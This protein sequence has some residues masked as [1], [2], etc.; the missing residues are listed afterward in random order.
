[1]TSA[2]SSGAVTVM[3]P[4]C[5]SALINTQTLRV[6]SSTALRRAWKTKMASPSIKDLRSLAKMKTGDGPRSGYRTQRGTFMQSL[7]AINCVRFLGESEAVTT[8]SSG[9]RIQ[10]GD[11]KPPSCP[12]WA[13]TRCVVGKDGLSHRFGCGASGFLP[14]TALWTRTSGVWGTSANRA[15]P[16]CGGGRSRPRLFPI[17]EDFEQ[18]WCTT[19]PNTWLVEPQR[20]PARVIECEVRAWVIWLG[21][22]V[23]QRKESQKEPEILFPVRLSK[24]P[25]R[26]QGSR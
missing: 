19:G 3:Q 2:C 20:L 11:R 26:G 8:R 22:T 9:L 25:G 24:H 5:S 12:K 23:S 13:A 4:T 18:E 6:Q 10:L 1:L 21:K 15:I 7:F 17:R 14:F 16:W